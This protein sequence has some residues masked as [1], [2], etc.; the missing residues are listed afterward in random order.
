VLIGGRTTS[1]SSL[2]QFVAA[3]VALFTVGL[4]ACGGDDGSNGGDRAEATTSTSAGPTTAVSLR[5]STSAGTAPGS[6]PTP[7]TTEATA[8]TLT[9]PTTSAS[10]PAPPALTSG[11]VETVS[12]DDS[13]VLVRDEDGR[14]SELGCEGLPEPVLLRVPVDGGDRTPAFAEA[15]PTGMLVRLATGQMAVVHGCEEFLSS[16]W[17]ADEAA[18]GA[19]SN[20]TETPAWRGPAVE[21]VQATEA[22][23]QGAALRLLGSS[24]TAGDPPQ[25]IVEVDLTTGVST[26]LL[27]TDGTV[28]AFAGMTEGRFALTDGLEVWVVDGT[29]AELARYPGEF[30]TAAPDRATLAVVG[31]GIDIIGP[32]GSATSLPV[33]SEGAPPAI[34]AAWAPN[35]RALAY[36]ARGENDVLALVGLDGTVT[37]LDE[38]RRIV[39]PAFSPSGAVLAW[40]RLVEDPDGDR[41]EVAAVTLDPSLGTRLP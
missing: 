29:G 10:S 34:D 3:G 8:T 33:A 14:Y 16:L 23:P 18:D 9:P 21:G 20:A 7:S 38:A 1:G 24:F 11:L 31:P 35:G 37:P 5:T 4:A 25:S 28:V 19:L 17:L 36:V 30:V 40:S 41:F 15:T 12:T 32:D 2:R 39:R 27:T 6:T 22:A 26:R 13:T